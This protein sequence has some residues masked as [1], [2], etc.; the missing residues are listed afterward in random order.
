MLCAITTVVSFSLQHY[1]Q[2]ELKA[3]IEERPALRL[4]ALHAV[5]YLLTQLAGAKAKELPL[6][7]PRAWKAAFADWD[8]KRDFSLAL[9]HA[10]RLTRILTD[11]ATA[12]ILLEQAQKFPERRE[13]L[14][15]FLERAEPRA[16]AMHE[17]ILTTGDRL[18]SRLHGSEA[19]EKKAE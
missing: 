10:E 17:E 16:R 19:A 15:R 5:R 13:L 14:E 3:M 8:P 18:L 4:T 9:L 12:E 2:P 11:Q 6:T 7:N 1:M